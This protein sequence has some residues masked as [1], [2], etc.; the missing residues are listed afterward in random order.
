MVDSSLCAVYH[1]YQYVLVYHQLWTPWGRHST[2]A[3]LEIKR[4]LSLYPGGVPVVPSCACTQFVKILAL[5]NVCQDS[6]KFSTIE[7]DRVLA[8]PRIC[9]RRIR[10]PSDFAARWHVDYTV[11]TAPS[12]RFVFVCTAF[13]DIWHMCQLDS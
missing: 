6:S 7:S 11:K 1:V 8:H 12:P 13:V 5:K 4:M 10:W 9:T 3:T 2:G